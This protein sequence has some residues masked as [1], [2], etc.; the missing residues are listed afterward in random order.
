ML[1][2]IMDEEFRLPVEPDRDCRDVVERLVALLDAEH[3]DL[4]GRDVSVDECAI[5]WVGLCSSAR[6]PL[7][8][9]RDDAICEAPQAR[10]PAVHEEDPTPNVRV[11][12][13]ERLQI[14]IEYTEPQAVLFVEIGEQDENLLEY[15][16]ELDKGRVVLPMSFVGS[17]REPLQTRHDFPV[18][19]TI[20]R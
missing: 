11:L 13:K 6:A 16:L 19:A 1:L 15:V 7:E 17:E 14:A 2:L 4:H 12:F 20:L 18:L 8:Q 5:S 9:L 10:A 3:V